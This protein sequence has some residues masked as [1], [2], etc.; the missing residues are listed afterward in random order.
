MEPKTTCHTTLGA[1]VRRQLAPRFAILA[2]PFNP[3]PACPRPR[4]PAKKDLLAAFLLSLTN[5]LQ[6][7]NGQFHHGESWTIDRPI[8]EKNCNNLGDC[9][10]RACPMTTSNPFPAYAKQSPLLHS[11]KIC[12]SVH[13]PDVNALICRFLIVFIRF[14]KQLC[15][16]RMRSLAYFPYLPRAAFARHNGSTSSTMSCGCS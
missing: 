6:E 16:C 4:L 11:S 12:S 14:H 5:D 2:G 9:Y 8:E 1:D 10:N 15:T 3:Y 13:G 7:V